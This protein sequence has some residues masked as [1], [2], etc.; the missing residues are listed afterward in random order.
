MRA[1]FNLLS[2]PPNSMDKRRWA[3]HVFRSVKVKFERLETT[4][5]HMSHFNIILWNIKINF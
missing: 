1:M 5:Q 2:F 4:E 3:F